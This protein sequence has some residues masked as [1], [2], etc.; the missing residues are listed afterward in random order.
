MANVGYVKAIFDANTTKLE[1][2]VKRA[3]RSLSKFGK[4]AGKVM[5]ALKS[6]TVL[7]FAAIGAAAGKMASDFESSMV[8]IETLVG[9]S[10]AE[11]DRMER[12]VKQLAGETARAPGELAEAMFFIAS[13]GL[14]GAAATDVLTAS[15][16]AAAIGLGDT[17][18]IADLATSAL[19]AYGAENLSAVKA[20]DILTAA[21]REGKLQS[22]ELAG[23]MG[24]VLPIASAMGVSFDEVGAAFAALSR[25][26][27]QAS[28]AATQLR[29]ILASILRPTKQSE[30]AMEGLGLSAAG[31]R[32]QIKDEGLLSVLKTLAESFD[33]Q[34]D[35]AALVFGNIRA[36]M[37]VMD[38]LGKNSGTTEEIFARM[39][40]TTGMVDKAFERVT[41]TSGF[42]LNQAL[43]DLKL[44][45]M[46]IG[47]LVLPEFIELLEDVTGVLAL[48]FG[49]SQ[50]AE[51]TLQ[52]LR[53]EMAEA[54]NASVILTTDI[55]ALVESMRDFAGLNDAAL[56][57]LEA[58]NAE[59]TAMNGMSV[60]TRRGFQALGGDFS[61][62][63]DAIES[64]SDVYRQFTD[65][66]KATDNTTADL[67]RAL[68]EVP[69]AF[70]D[71]ED[72]ILAAVRAGEMSADQV[73]EMALSLHSASRAQRDHT[74][75]L[76]DQAEAFFLDET[77]VRAYTAALEGTGAGTFLDSSMILDQIDALIEAG[78]LVEALELVITAYAGVETAAKAAETSLSL[79]TGLIV[80]ETE[81]IT[82]LVTAHD[83]LV[84]AESVRKRA[85]SMRHVDLMEAE[86][87]AIKDAEAAHLL[88]LDVERRRKSGSSLVHADLMEAE[89]QATKEAL[90]ALW[91][92]MNAEDAR[93]R[94][95]SDNWAVNSAQL[96]NDNLGE[97]ARRLLDISDLEAMILGTRQASADEAR[98][99]T[100]NVISLLR[101]DRQ[102]RQTE[103][104]I[105]QLLDERN[106]LLGIGADEE[107]MVA[108]M[109][110][111]Q[112]AI[113]DV[114]LELLAMAGE[115]TGTEREME[116][117]NEAQARANDLTA[118]Q[119]QQL[120]EATRALHAA[121]RAE[122]GKYGS[123]I[124]RIAAE[125]ALVALQA[126]IF[127]GTQDVAD[128]TA[129]LEEIDQQLISASEQLV[130]DQLEV[131]DAYS[132]VAASGNA[133]RDSAQA[134]ATMFTGTLGPAAGD[135]VT[136]MDKLVT[137]ASEVFPEF[138]EL[139]V[140]MEGIHFG[141]TDEQID[142]YVRS[143]R[144][145]IDFA[146]MDLPTIDTMLSIPDTASVISQVQADLDNANLG[147]SVAV[148]MAATPA[149]ATGAADPFAG[150]PQDQIDDLNRMFAA[151]AAGTWTS[152]ASGGIVDS[153]T[154]ALIGEAGPEAVIPIG[155]GG[156]GGGTTVN[157][158]VAGSILTES[159]IGEI[160]QEQLLR[161][162]GRNQTLEFA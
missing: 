145:M 131:N 122:E 107:Q 70:G 79:M 78:G 75:D 123:V 30:E 84:E 66:M 33:G 154:L 19:N 113:N 60:E 48:F 16:K 6:K 159:E 11:V 31:L 71:Q 97:T 88:L 68:N 90:L 26:G 94:A 80:E 160:V 134:L 157:V 114:E 99:A 91:A 67:M 96:L 85:T 7:A 89:E 137:K 142:A 2:G 141:M 57:V 109:E 37:G 147:M 102:V 35:A 156:M 136:D 139:R 77:A 140:A 32:K 36:L 112:K 72:A 59:I 22:D 101:A 10:A 105:N 87:Q 43:V 162:Q 25:T 98:D 34:S 124:N 133:A 29:G 86:E 132:L 1:K 15:A 54:G 111:Q 20:T 23:S 119:A 56:P 58:F 83:K 110:A 153:P 127:T 38:L 63:N 45:M 9:R 100:K 129:R 103:K 155:R 64:G 24:R 27:T 40:D 76:E 130:L 53:E 121:T 95:A 21:V 115:L 55:D 117:L 18:T 42:K 61:R 138:D 5:S 17:A 106:E 41:E 44:A 93:K 69:G 65:E 135:V 13:A 51:E 73:K 50:V 14:E 108:Q 62:H 39:A 46:D 128:A 8:K 151:I 150:L 161:I 104:A 74:K 82:P 49:N 120:I 144:G 81:A 148:S 28:E 116:Y 125:D 126:S 4:A 158:N 152:M 143:V 118:A 3:D 12:A 47:E 92:L 52:L 149:A 146:G